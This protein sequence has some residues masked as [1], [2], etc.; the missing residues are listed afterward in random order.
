[1]PSFET[2]RR[3]A[4]TP[5]QM[6][7]LVADVERYPEFFPLCEALAVRSRTEE[8]DRTLLVAD[9]T[10]GYKAFREKIASR[11]TVDRSRMTVAA[12]L[13]EGPFRHLENRWAFAEAPGGADVRFAISY[14]FKSML[15]QMVVGAVFDQ[16]FRRCVEAFEA[17]ARQVYGDKP[18]SA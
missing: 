14:E 7:D 17:R 13:V 12:D 9:M 2:T 18:G 15:L 6:L 8:G 10:V 16:A 11:V 3:V 4:F 1:M 5:R